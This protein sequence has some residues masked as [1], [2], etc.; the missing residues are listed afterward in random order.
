MDIIE[1]SIYKIFWIKPFNKII[2]GQKTKK[3]FQYL[4]PKKTLNLNCSED[5]FP[6]LEFNQN[7]ENPVPAFC[8][9]E[10]YDDVVNYFKFYP[11][12]RVFINFEK[13]PSS[14][15]IEDTISFILNNGLFSFV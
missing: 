8:V 9:P 11:F 12:E 13:T 15:N 10:N 3:N 5:M 2:L 4:L 7:P 1:T 6:I 14:F